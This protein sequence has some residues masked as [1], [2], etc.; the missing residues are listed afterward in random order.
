MKRSHF[1]RMLAPAIALPLALAACSSSSSTSAASSGATSS[2]SLSVASS[3]AAGSS[4]SGTTSAAMATAKLRVAEFTKAPSSTLPVS[5]PVTPPKNIKIAFTWCAQV[6]CTSIASGIQQA[7]TA[8]HA[9][10]VAFHHDDTASTV[11]TAFTNAITA[12]PTMVL[13]SG[14]PSEWY[15]PQLNQLAAKKIPVV[16]WSI[17]AGYHTSG[18]AANIISNDD[19]YF[20]GM[21]EADYVAVQT[22]GKANILLESAP[23]YPV[24]ATQSAGFNYEIKQVCPSCTVTTDNFSVPQ[25]ASGANVA[26]TVNTL[27][28]NPTTNWLVAT[29]GCLITQQLATA[30]KSAGFSSLKAIEADGTA[31]NY[32]LIKSGQL[33]VADI[34]LAEQYLGWLAVYDGLLAASGKT[35]PAF[36]APPYSTVPGHPDTL[37]S[38]LPIQIL[39]AAD[40]SNPNEVYDPIP[41]YQQQFEKLWGIS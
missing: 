16:A 1:I 36:P 25:L 5:T 26:A 30:V 27:Q 32:Q 11:S 7:A 12:N 19:Y 10:F 14:D 2:S 31:S 18:F 21:L 34:A 15:Q 23:Q 40:I 35:V 6:V 24:L 29:C 28:R 38:G 22:N 9:S 4:A 13:T 17:P 37:T 41:G 3:P 39:T 20:E 8:L 33:V